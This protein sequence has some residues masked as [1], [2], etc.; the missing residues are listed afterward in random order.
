M[1]VW[2]IPLTLN[3][4][5][6]IPR[7]NEGSLSLPQEV[8]EIPEVHDHVHENHCSLEDQ[9]DSGQESTLNDQNQSSAPTKRE[10][11]VAIVRQ[12]PKNQQRNFYRRRMKMLP[13]SSPTKHHLRY[14]S[15]ISTHDLTL[16]S[17]F[18]SSSTPTIVSKFT[19]KTS[20]HARTKTITPLGSPTLAYLALYK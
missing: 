9:V 14:S 10:H 15:S 5:C 12:K 2:K 7:F 17:Y 8:A 6:C 11:K 1:Y 18:K 16:F 13:F 3:S 19:A 20:R 4:S